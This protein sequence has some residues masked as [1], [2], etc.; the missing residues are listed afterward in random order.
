M[1]CI[2]KVALKQLSMV[3]LLAASLGMSLTAAAQSATLITSLSGSATDQFGFAIDAS[4]AN[5]AVGAWGHDDQRGAVIMYAF[6]GA[7]YRVVDTLKSPVYK[8]SNYRDRFGCSVAFYGDDYLAVGARG[9]NVTGL[10]YNTGAVLVY[11]YNGTSWELT[12]TI[13]GTTPQGGF[14]AVVDMPDANHIAASSLGIG[15]AK[16]FALNGDGTSTQVGGDLSCG[17]NADISMPTSTT[18]AL[19]DVSYS[20]G[21]ANGKVD[22][23]DW[24]G[25]SWVAR[26][27]IEGPLNSTNFGQSISMPDDAT[28]AISNP[29]SNQ[30]SIYEW[31]SPNWSQKGATISGAGGF[32]YAIDMYDATKVLVGAIYSTANAGGAEQYTWNGTSWSLSSDYNGVV[33]LANMGQDVAYADA[34]SYAVSSFDKIAVDYAK[35]SS[36]SEV[37]AALYS[38]TLEVAAGSNLAVNNFYVASGAQVNLRSNS[39]D[40]YA[41]LKVNGTMTVNGTV[42]MEQTVSVASGASGLASPMTTGWTNTTGANSERLYIYDADAGAYIFDAASWTQPGVGFFAPITTS[43]GFMAGAGTF[44]VSGTPNTSHTH[45]LGFVANTQNGGSG[46]GWNL[47]GNPYTCA[48]DWSTV[49]KTNV[50]DAIY[51]WDQTI[52]KY[53][54]YVNGIAAPEN[55]GTQIQ[56]IVAPMQSF[57]VQS[58]QAGASIA[59]T[60]ASNGTVASAPTLYKSMPDQLIVGLK[61]MSDTTIFDY[62]WLKLMS[63]MS[64]NFDGTEDAWKWANGGNNV[65]VYSVANDEIFAVNAIDVLGGKSIELGMDAVQGESYAITLEAITNGTQYSVTLEDRLNGGLWDLGMG[66]YNF[67][68]VEWTGKGTRFVVHIDQ[69][70]VGVEESDEVLVQVISKDGALQLS[71]ELAEAVLYDVHNLSGQLVAQGSLEGLSKAK[72][73]V[74][75]AGVYVVSFKGANVNSTTKVLVAK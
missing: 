41:Q 61:S 36:S 9:W 14:G 22:V 66:D 32:G 15:T 68:N 12:H 50:N 8:V 29:G 43:N 45:S 24:N 4:N 59:T 37:S 1:L 19:S 44:T 30:V 71:N 23:Y 49:T 46:S 28:L 31:S 10:G 40:G 39:N 3:F 60:M 74:Q 13:T 62:T 64:D 55:P 17:V 48:L 58:T 7:A 42:N 20:S 51:I 25:T 69:S 73:E 34:N 63:G 18:V 38:G 2:K 53:N 35:V 33:A 11:H 47:I 56:P 70:V 21:T 27:A 16:V 6:D 54:Y 57:W 52:S 65:N 67:S 26:T 75:N 72:V 5:L